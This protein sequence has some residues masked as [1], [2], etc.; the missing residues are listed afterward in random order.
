MNLLIKKTLGTLLLLPLAVTLVDEA[1]SQEK[2]FFPLF[3]GKTLDNWDGNPEFWSVEDGA[4]TGTTTRENPVKGNTFLI[5]RGGEVD[6]FELRL[7]V[8]IIGGNTGIQYRSED[9]GQ[10]V[11][12]GYQADFEAGI[13]FSGILYHERGRGILARRGQKT[14]VTN[15]NGKHKVTVVKSLG[16]SADIQAVIKPEQWNDYTIIAKGYEF[17]H[18]INGRIT[19]EV[20]DLDEKSR[21]SSGILALQLHA[22]PPMRVQY[23]DIRI[24]PFKGINVSGKWQFRVASDWGT[25]EPAFDLKQEGE[26]VTGTYTGLF[27]TL[28]VTG[29][30]KGNRLSIQ[31]KGDYNGQTVVSKYEGSITGFHS[32]EGTVNFNEQFEATWTAKKH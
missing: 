23:K 18:L 14:M 15:E 31:I 17:T 8:K 22:G 26:Q 28:P 11:V 10:W 5:W 19:V 21:K 13:T 30:V 20:T 27:G 2:G 4:L 29:S 7:K 24:N 25:G 12:A 3:D 1:A 32:M 16:E 9:R 6:D